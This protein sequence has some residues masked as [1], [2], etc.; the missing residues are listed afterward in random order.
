MVRSNTS[1][2]DYRGELNTI[3]E[4]LMLLERLIPK[5]E[6]QESLL[7]DLL[8]ELPG[9]FYVVKGGLFK[10]ISPQL[11][12]ITGFFE[13]ELLGKSPLS[14]VFDEDNQIFKEKLVKLQKAKQAHTQQYRIVAKNATLRWVIEVASPI[15]NTETGD[16]IA[17]LIDITQLIE[18]EKLKNRTEELTHDLCEYISDMVHCTSPDG[19]IL[20][21]N[22]IWQES[23]GYRPDEV[24]N[25]SLSDIVPLDYKDYW[26]GALN[27]VMSSE[28][29]CDIDSELIHNRAGVIHV[30]GTASCK[31]VDNKPAYIRWILRDVTKSK[32]QHEES[33]AELNQANEIRKKLEESKKEFEEFIHVASHDL[34]EPLRK[35]S[36]FGA[37]LQ[38]STIN[39]LDND[40]CENLSFMIDGA[41]RMQSMIDDLLA[42]SR[43]NTRTMPFQPVDLNEVVENLRNFEIATTL[44]EASGELFVPN[45][46]LTVFGDLPQIHQLL[47]NLIINGLKFHKKEIPPEVTISSC[48]LPKNMVRISV[49]DNGIGVDPKHYEQIFV[50]F[51]R[52]HDVK[53]YNGTGIGLSICKKIVKRHGGKIGVNSK[54]GNGTVFWFTLPRFNTT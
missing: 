16:F 30:K 11:T 20:Y 15:M 33:E 48:L 32:E 1:T 38:E 50:M 35:I 49:Q 6:S 5:D 19:T 28:Q 7:K 9:A 41:L 45:P 23:T 36:S 8:Y 21:T 14:L 29:T 53:S 2:I 12:Q 13:A 44:E 43:I 54:P 39:G 26:L 27:Q 46:L 40:Q 42:Y 37:L 10:Y 18:A 4:H 3:R 34:R 31:F 47:Q 52:L 25:R 17:N 51:K 24:S 22:R